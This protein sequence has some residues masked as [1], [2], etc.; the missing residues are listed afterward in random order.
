MAD[1]QDPQKQEPKKQ[2]PQKPSET[3]LDWGT[4]GTPGAGMTD[5]TN[6]R[7]PPKTESDPHNVV[8][9][10]KT[11]D[12]KTEF[13]GPMTSSALTSL[14]DNNESLSKNSY[15]A[16][17]RMMNMPDD[18]FIT[19]MIPEGGSSDTQPRQPRYILQSELGANGQAV[20]KKLLKGNFVDNQ[21]LIESVEK[22][23]NSFPLGKRFDAE[24]IQDLTTR[25]EFKI[26]KDAKN[27][28]APS[29]LSISLSA[30]G[31]MTQP[32]ADT[33]NQALQTL[34]KYEL[35]LD[36]SS[37]SKTTDGKTSVLKSWPRDPESEFTIRQDATEAAKNNGKLS[38]YG[39]T[40]DKGTLRGLDEQIDKGSFTT[41]LTLTENDANGKPTQRILL[42]KEATA[43]ES[44]SPLLEPNKKVAFTRSF[45]VDNGKTSVLET[46]IELPITHDNFLKQ[47]DLDKMVEQV[48]DAVQKN[49]ISRLEPKGTNPHFDAL[50]EKG[51][52][53]SAEQS[54]ESGQ[55][56]PG[57]PVL[58]GP[59]SQPS[60][61]RVA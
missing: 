6:R 35:R 39:A 48:R 57:A 9:Y 52:S 28:K 40:F 21:G 1:I 30:E 54:M 41:I 33:L 23:E 12:G 7:T 3:K 8:T 47:A 43:T 5:F 36:S 61:S 2:E 26:Q 46:P 42:A 34:P 4:A 56:K 59:G 38:A 44:V 20:P 53:G 50:L 27:P 15:L 51:P 16:A 37:P 45:N 13:A 19:L 14:I 22:P 24:S 31:F 10:K 29:A 25:Q 11:S 32:A 60:K 17:I 55:L 18:I 49:Q 58:V